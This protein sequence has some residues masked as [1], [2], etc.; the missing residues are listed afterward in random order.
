VFD[1]SSDAFTYIDGTEEASPSIT[2]IG[3]MSSGSPIYIA[4]TKDI[5]LHLNGLV[6]EVRIYNKAL[7]ADEVS[8]NYNNGK[9]SHQ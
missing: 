2:S 4:T 9:S 8:K 3:D 5:N 6:D 7:S 1:R